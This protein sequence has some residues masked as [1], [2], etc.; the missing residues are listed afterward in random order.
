M[1]F[2]GDAPGEVEDRLS[3][4]RSAE[5]RAQVLK[6]AHHGSASST[7]SAFLASVD[8]QLAIISV[9]HGNRYGHPSPYV[10]RRLRA[11]DIEVRRSDRDGTLMIE[12]HRDGS[13]RLEAA[14]GR[15]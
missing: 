12:A 11:R 4:E 13:W 9:G 8:P 10:L 3:R 1:L 2:T 14:A 15:W 7:S 6:V 5:L